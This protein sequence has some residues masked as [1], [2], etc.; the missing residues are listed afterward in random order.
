M[1]WIEWWM[2]LKI[3]VPLGMLVIGTPIWLW[4]KLRA[5]RR[6]QIRRSTL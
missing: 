4:I 5:E 6:R 1:S 2:V 3:V